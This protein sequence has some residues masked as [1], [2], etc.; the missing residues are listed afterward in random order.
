MINTDFPDMVGN[1]C[2][3]LRGIDQA[4]LLSQ[5]P[6]H[7]TFDVGEA[8]LAILFK[9]SQNSPSPCRSRRQQ[10]EP[11]TPVCA[12]RH[13]IQGAARCGAGELVVLFA[14]KELADDTIINRAV[15]SESF[16]RW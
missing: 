13:L 4:Q 5:S 14:A 6:V 11:H 15:Q 2:V 12:P 16:M 1:P 7:P 8:L 9:S 3:A 10:S